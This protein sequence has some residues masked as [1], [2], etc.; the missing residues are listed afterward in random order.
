MRRKIT[1]DIVKQEFDERGY[2]LISTEYVK[3]SEK[4][5]YI[6]PKHRERGVLEITFANFTK[7]R[8]CPY[9][10]HRIK[11]TQDDYVAELAT[12]KPTIEVLGQ[13]KNLKTKILHRCKVCGYEWNVLPDN[14]L[15]TNN[16]CPKCGKR[17]SL[18]QEEFEQR[19]ADIDDS[20]IV[21]GKYKTHQEK[22][23]FGCSHCGN[24]WMAKPN[25]ILNGRGCPHC[26]SSKGELKISVV[27]DSMQI[28]YIEQKRFKDCKYQAV[29]PFDFYISE[30]NTCIEYDGL[31]HY[32]S[33]TF[34]GIS[35]EQ[36]KKNLELCKIKD[37][38]KT[39]Y[40]KD[41]NINLIRI[42]Y[43][44][45]KNIENILSSSLH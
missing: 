16:G 34:G 44:D 22:I 5:K 38:I 28:E 17:A 18:A 20:I 39:Q 10:A 2:E 3:N 21:I 6:C 43:W 40:C 45:Y 13:Y 12:K 11:K 1:Y 4:L 26:K 23:L 25:N 41:N 37:S 19:V 27:L 31:Q 15:N 7:G 36:A 29:L 8:G 9:C 30:Y 33:C 32:E 24:S 14:M 35:E 42:P